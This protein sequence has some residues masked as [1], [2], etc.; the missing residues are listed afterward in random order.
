MLHTVARLIVERTIGT[1]KGL[2]LCLSS[3]G[4]PLQYTPEKACNIVMACC[5]LHNM[6]IKHGIPLVQED[7]PDEA[8][9]DAPPFQ[10]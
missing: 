3:A 2:W 8:M 6:A 4:G 9:P 5:V 1:L 7:Q 10:P